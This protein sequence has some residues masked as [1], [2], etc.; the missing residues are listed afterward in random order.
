RRRQKLCGWRDRSRAA[1]VTATSIPAIFTI[2]EANRL[3]ATAVGSCWLAE[4]GMTLP[5]GICLQTVA[6]SLAALPVT[7]SL[8]RLLA[9]GV[10]AAYRLGCPESGHQK[11]PLRLCD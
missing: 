10:R 4:I 1:S 9:A 7:A 11:R 8:R 3:F 5:S 6:A 2:R